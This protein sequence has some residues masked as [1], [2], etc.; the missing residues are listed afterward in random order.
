MNN[1]EFDKDGVLLPS[2]YWKAEVKSVFQAAGV[3]VLR[4]MTNP[5]DI[6]GKPICA[7]MRRMK[8]SDLNVESV[9]QLNIL[10]ISV[11][12]IFDYTDDL[13]LRM[14]YEKAA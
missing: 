7:M 10:K 12:K 8:K 6:I 13:L 5:V 9:K 2:E 4:D 1:R 3:E 14:H 11:W